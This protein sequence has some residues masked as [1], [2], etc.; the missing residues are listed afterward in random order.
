[1]DLCS[2][3]SGSLTTSL[4]CGIYCCAS[5]VRIDYFFQQFQVPKQFWKPPPFGCGVSVRCCFTLL[6]DPSEFSGLLFIFANTPQRKP[7]Y[8]PS[9]CSSSSFQGYRAPIEEVYL[10]IQTRTIFIPQLSLYRSLRMAVCSIFLI[11]QT[12]FSPFTITSAPAEE[13]VSVH[14]R[15]FFFFLLT[16]YRLLEIG[17]EIYGTF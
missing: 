6:N 15:V 9:T 10:Q 17:L 4:S 14:I 2:T 12:F 13:F 16:F 3:F 5:T 1:V 8:H 11:T 7:R